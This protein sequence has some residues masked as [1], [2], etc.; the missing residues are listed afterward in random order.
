MAIPKH[1]MP[2][3]RA[4]TRSKVYLDC[5]FVFDGK[6]YDAVIRNISLLGAFLWSAFIPPCDSIVTIK[7]ETP[8]MKNLIILEGSVVRRDSQYTERDTAG[9]FAITFCSSSPGLLR[10]IDKLMHPQD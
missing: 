1:P 10:L 2:D 4:A 6:E 3:R 9:A 8:L 5:R 7:L